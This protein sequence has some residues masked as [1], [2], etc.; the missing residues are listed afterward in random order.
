VNKDIPA[1]PVTL[2]SGERYGQ[3][4]EHD[5]M[6][7]RDFF[8]GKELSKMNAVACCDIPD[9]YARQAEHCYRMADAMLAARTK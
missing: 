7:L 5:G 6:T 1:F 8:A 3:H 2:M 4:A 9:A